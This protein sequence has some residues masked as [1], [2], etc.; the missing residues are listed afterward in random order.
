MAVAH[1][2]RLDQEESRLDFRSGLDHDSDRDTC[3]VLP[4]DAGAGS[5]P[6]VAGQM[7]QS[8]AAF[9]L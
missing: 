5:H 4:R 8:G 7:D 9:L 2:D 6:A 3:S 1:F